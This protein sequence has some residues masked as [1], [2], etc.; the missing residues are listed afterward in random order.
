[1]HLA[2]YAKVSEVACHDS[3]YAVYMIT[4]YLSGRHLPGVDSFVSTQ[5]MILS[6]I[7]TIHMRGVRRKV[8]NESCY[9]AHCLYLSYS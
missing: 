9:N 4:L 7:E 1:M 5:T 3:K 2:S 6:V 8:I